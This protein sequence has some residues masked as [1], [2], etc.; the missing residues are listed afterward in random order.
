MMFSD[1]HL[2]ACV[3]RNFYRTNCQYRDNPKAAHS[4]F[5]DVIPCHYTAPL[6]IHGRNRTPNTPIRDAFKHRSIEPP[7]VSFYLKCTREKN[8]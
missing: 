3:F 6:W 1:T 8:K 7:C 2:L 5:S 4:G